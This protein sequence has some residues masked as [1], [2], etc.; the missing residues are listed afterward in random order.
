MADYQAV[1]SDAFAAEIG[2][3]SIS[4]RRPFDPAAHD[5]EPS[6]RLTRFADLKGRGCKVPQEVL[7]KLVSSLQQ[8]YSQE[9]DNF[10]H[11]SVP[12]IGIGLDCSV[13]PLRHGRL[14]FIFLSV[15][16]LF[17]E[18]TTKKQF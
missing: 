6:F 14:T 9:Q 15:F 4:L 12:R 1:G 3:S 5:L 2:G 11:I 17:C 16:V 10:M 13:T 8:D 7:N 18:K